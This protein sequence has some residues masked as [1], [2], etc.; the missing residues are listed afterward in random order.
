MVTSALSGEWVLTKAN[1]PNGGHV[2]LFRAVF[3]SSVVFSTVLLIINILDPAK[4]SV[5]SFDELRR[6][7]VDRVPWYGAIFVGTYAGLYARFSAQ[8]TYLAD[9]YNRIKQAEASGGDQQVL[10]QWKAGFLEDA[11]N[12]HLV[13]KASLV[14]VAKSWGGNELV[15]RAFIEFTPGGKPRF[16]KLMKRVTDA[17]QRIE[18]QLA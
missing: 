7:I 1:L 13:T 18:D 3:A 14:S 5:F 15:E 2:V 12:L 16:E 8:W 9:L 4:T 17:H 11:E 10:A 6:Q